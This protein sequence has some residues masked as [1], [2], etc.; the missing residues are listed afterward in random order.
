MRACHLV[1]TEHGIAE[2][3][4]AEWPQ[5]SSKYGKGNEALVLV[6][7]AI[8]LVVHSEERARCVQIVTGECAKDI[9]ANCRHPRVVN[10]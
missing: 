9:A 8:N 2:R 7:V 10:L 5:D 6:G 1:V 3:R 4:E